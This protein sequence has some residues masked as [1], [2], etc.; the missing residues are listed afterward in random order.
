MANTVA[1]PVETHRFEIVRSFPSKRVE[2]AWREFLN[3]V[4]SPEQYDAPDFFLEP[5]WKGCDPF[6][7]LAF[8]NGG[9]IVG[10]ATGLHK[11]R[12]VSC[13]LQSRPQ[14]CI[15]KD[16]DASLASDALVDGLLA[17]AGDAQL[18]TVYGWEWTPLPSFSRRG[19]RVRKMEGNVILDLQPGIERLFNQL[20]KSRR[21]DIRAALRNG[22][23]V[24]EEKTPEDLAAYLDVFSAWLRTSRKKIHIKPDFS[25]TAKI[26]EM[27]DNHRRFLARYQ[28]KVIAGSS[29]RFLRGGMMVYAGN[30]S[31]DEYLRLLPNDLLLWKTIEWG[32]EQGFSTYSLGGA[33]P[34]LRKCGGTIVPIY[35]YRLDRTFLRRYER[36]EELGDAARLVLRNLPPAAESAIRRV[37]RKPKRR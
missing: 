7:I 32:C 36:S 18:V 4:E 37:L 26:H 30:C 35:R 31:Y 6:A 9:R 33:H 17:E 21:R 27:P 24:S 16:V 14:I 8:D 2:V 28:G 29:V 25:A 3:R 22:I 20:H 11:G 5:Y 23:E 1:S 12:T 34:F 10:S 19:F 15:A 13:G